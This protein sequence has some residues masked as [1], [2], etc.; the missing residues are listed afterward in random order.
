[1]RKRITIVLAQI[2]IAISAAAM[3]AWWI[4]LI[5]SFI[6]FEWVKIEGTL[7]IFRLATVWL[8]CFTF[9]EEVQD[10]LEEEYNKI[11]KKQWKK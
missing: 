11:T 1:M 3:L 5:L 9:T 6:V 10:D 8:F 7:A 4:H 2:I